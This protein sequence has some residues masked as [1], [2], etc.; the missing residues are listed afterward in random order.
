MTYTL[1]VKVANGNWVSLI[2]G[3]DDAKLK[4]YAFSHLYQLHWEVLPMPPWEGEINYNQMIG[5]MEEA[6]LVQFIDE[7]DK[8]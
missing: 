7:L 2:S 3:G 5:K 6:E 1:A 8:E 4:S